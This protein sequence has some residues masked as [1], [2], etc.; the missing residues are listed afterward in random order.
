MRREINF[1]WGQHFHTSGYWLRKYFARHI[2][3]PHIVTHYLLLEIFK[4]KT[5]NQH[6]NTCYR[7]FVSCCQT[8]EFLTSHKYSIWFGGGPRNQSNKFCHAYPV[9]TFILDFK[10]KKSCCKISRMLLWFVKCC[11]VV[12]DSPVYLLTSPLQ[13][14]HLNCSQW[15]PHIHPASCQL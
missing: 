8:P 4:M 15:C 1:C 13:S 3:P 2:P 6:F 12:S 9:Y 11:D 14:L 7:V 10:N 5:T